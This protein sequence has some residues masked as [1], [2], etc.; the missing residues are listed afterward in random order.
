MTSQCK[1]TKREGTSDGDCQRKRRTREEENQ[2]YRKLRDRKGEA[3]FTLVEL[4]V[5]MVILVLLA[6]LVAPRVMG[7]SR[8]L[9]F[10][11]CQ[12]ANRKPGNDARA[13]QT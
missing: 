13:L 11:G 10:Q 5:V 12:G 8:R 6:S 9:A 3:G 7:Y 1:K 2:G 4:L